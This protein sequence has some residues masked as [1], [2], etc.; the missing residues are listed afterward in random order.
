MK[1]VD[2]LLWSNSCKEN[3]DDDNT[4]DWTYKS[5]YKFK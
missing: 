1:I 2:K 4:N 3:D 5:W